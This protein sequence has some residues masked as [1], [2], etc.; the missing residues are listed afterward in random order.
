MYAAYRK[1]REGNP[2]FL[3]FKL[4]DGNIS[5]FGCNEGWIPWLLEM[6]LPKGQEEPFRWHL[7]LQEALRRE[8]AGEYAAKQYDSDVN[9]IL[10]NIKPGSD[11]LFLCEL[12]DVWGFSAHSWTPMLW[13]LRVLE[14]KGTECTPS[15]F[16]EFTAADDGDH[17]YEFLYAAGTVKNGK[18]QG[19]WIAPKSS[20]TNGALLWSPEPLNYFIER[21]KGQTLAAGD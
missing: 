6:A 5:L 21:I 17:V 3:R 14:P 2:N 20:P 13:H 19:S 8:A 7:L 18:I 11:E 1:E 16:G 4:V 9:A 15:R 12:L 10:I